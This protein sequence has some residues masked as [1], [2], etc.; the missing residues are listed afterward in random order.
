MNP[1]IFVSMLLVGAAYYVGAWTGVHQTITPEGIAVLWPPNAILLSAFLVLPYRR[2]PL[3]ALAAMAAE[4]LADVP[5][6]PLWAAGAFGMVNIF[7][8]SLAAVLIRRFVPTPF[9]FDR[10]RSGWF[11]LLFGPLLVS[12]F[13]ALLGAGVYI[14]LGRADTPYPALWQIWWFGDAL[15]LLLLTPPI[16]V[17]WRWL[18]A[19]CPGLR[20]RAAVEAGLLW[21]VIGALGLK[22]F[23][24]SPPATTEL[25]FTQFWFV[26]LGILAALRLGVLGAAATV[27]LIAALAVGNLV[28]GTHPY[29]SVGPQYAVWLTQEYLTIVAVVSVGLALLLKEI[30]DQREAL[31]KNKRA[32]Q[33][34]NEI[35]EARVNERTLA[36]EKSNQALQEANQRLAAIAAIDELTGI[37]NRRHF[38]EEAQRE[39]SR[40]GKDGAEATVI[41]VDLDHFKKINDE[42]GHEAGDVVLRAITGPLRQSIRPRDLMGRMGGEEFVVLLSG[43]EK[44]ASARVAERIRAA[45]EALTVDYRDAQI[46]LTA[47]FGVAQW[48][49]QGTLDDLVRQAD[50]AL[51]RAKANGRNRVEI[52]DPSTQSA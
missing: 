16:V 52:V 12:G 44:K 38:R 1:K 31:S 15:G 9:N 50:D 6:F 20:W 40:L 18:E 45:I 48:D 24:A 28:R 51:Y 13:A 26:P 27:T 22:A 42:Y 41:M 25:Y 8:A 14:L 21:L 5:V 43:L 35:L 49:G 46:R 34:Y 36:L 37:P 29:I 4:I 7:E 30:S 17:V 39:M 11:F 23:T 19:G 3:I 2:W 32:L 10:L 33:I 47:S